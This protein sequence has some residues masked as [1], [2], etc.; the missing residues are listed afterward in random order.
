MSDL[1]TQRFYQ[2]FTHNVSDGLYKSCPEVTVDK[3]VGVGVVWSGETAVLRF[4]AS[5]FFFGAFA[6]RDCQ[7]VAAQPA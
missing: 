5:A 6:W 4:T 7:I 1:T 2:S 3:C